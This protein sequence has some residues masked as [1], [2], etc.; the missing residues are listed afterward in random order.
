MLR[1]NKKEAGLIFI[2]LLFLV[3]VFM[4]GVAG[5]S[6]DE[7][8]QL[9]DDLISSGYEWLIN[10]SLDYPSV[11]VYR[12]NSNELLAQFPAITGNDFSKY[13]IFLTNLSDGESYSVFDLRSFGDVEKIPSEI[14]EKKMRIDEI[15]KELKNG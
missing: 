15:R 6:Q 11:E 1:N 7:L 4:V 8:A 10:Y 5:G 2:G 12:E 3:G 9:E 14:Y 13:Q